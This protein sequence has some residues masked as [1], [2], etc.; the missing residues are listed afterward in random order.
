MGRIMPTEERRKYALE[1]YHRN[2]EKAAAYKKA[3]YERNKEA[4]L[5]RSKKFN[6]SERRKQWKIENKEKIAK[7]AQEWWKKNKY[8]RPHLKREYGITLEDYNVMFNEQQGKCKV[9][10]KHQDT[11]N[12]PLNVDHCHTTGKIRGLLC[13]NC[14]LLK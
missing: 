10:F 11:L 4:C 5:E 14:S 13:R 3:Y 1:W 8:K 12:Y 7:K 9:C 2:K 6:Q